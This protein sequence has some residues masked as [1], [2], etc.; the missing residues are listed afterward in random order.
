MYLFNK[1]AFGHCIAG[2]YYYIFSTTSEI[3]YITSEQNVIISHLQITFFDVILQAMAWLSWFYLI[4][5][6]L[7]R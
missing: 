6:K 7:G 3:I 5:N 1:T 2:I 4:R